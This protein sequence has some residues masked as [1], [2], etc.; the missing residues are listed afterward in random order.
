[1][2]ACH[3]IPCTNARAEW[4]LVRPVGIQLHLWTSNVLCGLTYFAEEDLRV[5]NLVKPA[6]TWMKA[7]QN[8]DGG[9]G[10]SLDTYQYPAR[11]GCGTSTAS[12]TAWALMGLLAHLPP[13]DGA[14]RKGVAFLVAAQT[15]KVGGG[16]SWPETEYTG[17]G[18]PGFFYIG[19]SLYP[20]YFPMMAL[21]RYVHSTAVS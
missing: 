17:T 1:M 4:R 21:G 14:I 11:A 12:Q 10:E 15:K 6:N 8:T 16:A 2:Q 3:H 5:Q 13:T 20:H 19:Y 9:W 7:I 18:F